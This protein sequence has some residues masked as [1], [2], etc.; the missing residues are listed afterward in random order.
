MVDGSAPTE[1]AAVGPTAP[2]TRPDPSGTRAAAVREPGPGTGAR[3]SPTIEE[4]ARRAGVGRG[5]AS[6]VVNGSPQVSEATRDAVLRAVAEL[7]YVPNRA[8]RSLVTRRTDTVALV[9]SE[10]GDRVFGEPYFAAVVRGI[11]ERIARSHVQLVLTMAGSRRDRERVATYLTDQYVDGALMLSLHAPDDLPDLVESGGVPTVCGGRAAGASPRCVVDVDNRSGG[12]AAVAHLLATGRR[13]VAVLTGPQDMSSGRDRLAG[14][15]DA[16]SDAGLPP[17]ALLVE[18]GDY[19]EAS[20]EYAMRRVLRFGPPP[21]AVFAASD[22]MAVGAMRVLR[23]AGLRVPDDVA[24]VGFDD[25][26][27]AR[28][29]EPA[30]TSVHQ[31]V[32]E[33]GRVM[34]DLLL[35]RISGEDVPA[36]TVLPTRL[37]VR[38]TA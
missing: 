13:R 37:V 32:E 22:L 30:L 9:V 4:V 24:V 34:A 14:A 38:A 36:R 10:S 12:R 7:G 19:S 21:D 5:T 23:E 29:T 2:P 28:H 33:M 15:R 18:P 31:P 16:V 17:E 6:R 1:R 8:A 3:R 27:V 20:G 11:G 35:A 26:P 25:S